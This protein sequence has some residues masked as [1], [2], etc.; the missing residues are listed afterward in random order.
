MRFEEA[1]VEAY[2][3]YRGEESP[4]TVR[5][6]GRSFRVAEVLDRW[7]EGGV[8]PEKLLVTYFRVRTTDGAELI[9]KYEE[10]TGRWYLRVPEK[11]LH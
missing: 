1:R 11:T 10:E 7:Y 8:D 5:H 6:R 4:R 9:L 3:G 2:A